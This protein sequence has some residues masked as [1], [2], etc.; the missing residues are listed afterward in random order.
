MESVFLQV[1]MS[2][3]PRLREN[4]HA[5]R[6]SHTHMHAQLK[7]LLFYLLG[8][9]SISDSFSL[10]NKQKYVVLYLIYSMAL[11][12]DGITV[13]TGQSKG[14]EDSGIQVAISLKIS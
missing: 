14:S 3:C 1:F 5:Y 8:L 12:S 4:T 13:A 9:K 7:R 6:H 11:H 2:L 10:K